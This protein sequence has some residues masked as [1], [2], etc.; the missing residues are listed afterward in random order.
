M[1]TLSIIPSFT[2]NTTNDSQCADGCVPVFEETESSIVSEFSLVCNNRLLRTLPDSLF[3]AGFLLG[4]LFGG[5]LTDR[6]GRRKNC[7]VNRKA[8]KT[9]TEVLIEIVLELV[10]QLRNGLLHVLVPSA[11][12]N[13]GIQFDAFTQW[14]F[15][16]HVSTP[17][18]HY[19]NF[20]KTSKRHVTMPSTVL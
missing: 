7:I 16:R 15:F 13:H 9:S 2:C 8:L 20:V 19:G 18:D 10:L 11:R 12:R 5:P 1:P 17:L 3:M 6:F 14:L 4:A